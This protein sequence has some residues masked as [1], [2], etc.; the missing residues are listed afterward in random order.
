MDKESITSYGYL[1][2]I[3][4]SSSGFVPDSKIFLNCLNVSV[5]GNDII[6][7]F[8]FH[9]SNVHMGFFL[10]FKPFESFRFGFTSLSEGY[11]LVS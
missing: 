8:R 3:S 10:L 7:L 6:N 4:Y 11:G 9:D 5:T 2:V 1:F